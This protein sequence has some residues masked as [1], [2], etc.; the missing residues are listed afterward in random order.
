MV[1]KSLYSILHFH[2]ELYALMRLY[3]RSGI[4]VYNDNYYSV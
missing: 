3:Y 1:I 4:S 2:L